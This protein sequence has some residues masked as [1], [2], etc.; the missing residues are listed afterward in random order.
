MDDFSCNRL[1]CQENIL[2][3]SILTQKIW[4]CVLFFEK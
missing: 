3:A 2:S 1:A 4:P